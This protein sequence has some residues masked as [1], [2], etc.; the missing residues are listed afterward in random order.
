MGG[1]FAGVWS[2]LAAARVKD[3][4]GAAAQDMEITLVS[5]RPELH[6]RPRLHEEAPHRMS[7]P[8]GPLL[9]VAGARFVE[10]SVERILDD[11]AAVDVET[12]SGEH[13][14][15]PCDRL[16]LTSGSRLHRPA[17]LPGVVEYAYS[18]D[19]LED[20]VAL[21][22]HLKTLADQPDS[23]ARN[24]V[25]VVGCG[26]T[27][28]EVATELPHRLRTLFGPEADI[29]VVIV[30]N[31]EEVGPDI[32]PGPRPA[33]IEA[34]DALGVQCVLGSAVVS[35]D[36]NGVRTASGERIESHTVIWSGGMVA[37]PLTR[38]LPAPIDRLGRL[39]VTQQLRVAGADRVFAAGDV[40]RALT[41]AEGHHS[42]M[43]CQHA[44]VMGRF[45]GHNVAADLLGAPLLDY[46]QPFYATCLDLGEWGAVY[47]EGWEREVKLTQA[48][49][50]ARKRLINTQWIY[51]PA[52]NRADALAAGNPFI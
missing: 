36:A 23:R 10:G 25:V 47:T 46:R 34:L 26:F 19:Q 21:E 31:A 16:V 14:V 6:V 15:L 5:P 50:K 18:V 41:D 2:V 33:I 9:D 13:V 48:E 24:T 45:A 3:M 17:S 27:G 32:G 28:I 20:A 37:S 35:V 44:I 12:A 49:G 7:V 38:Q 51:P 1:G 4:A 43:S 39:D 11:G 40:A 42:L 22:T 29:R 8:L 30:G 52:A